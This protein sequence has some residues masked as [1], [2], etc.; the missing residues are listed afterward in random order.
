MIAAVATPPAP[1]FWDL[2][3]GQQFR[4]G[5]GVTTILPDIDFETACAAGYHWDEKQQKWTDVPGAAKNKRG[6]EVV[7]RRNYVKHPTFRILSLAYNLK[8]GRGKRR[9]LPGWP[10]PQDL[11]DH[12]ANGGIVEAWNAGFEFDVWNEYCVPVLGWPPLPLHQLRCAMAKARAHAGPGKLE[13]FGEA[14]RLTY[15]KDP[16]GDRL[17]RKFSN[18]RNPTKSNPK[19][20]TMPEDDPADFAKLLDYNDRDI[21]TEAEASLKTPDLPPDELEIWLTDQRVNLRGIQVDLVAMENCISIV[22]QAYAK[23]NAELR[24]ITNGVVQAASEVKKLTE[25]LSRCGVYMESLDEEAVDEMLKKLHKQGHSHSAAYRVLEIRSLLGSASIKKLFA[26]RHQ[27]HLGRLYD[28]YS[29]FAARTGRW[30]GNGPQPQNLPSGM[31]HTLE[32]VERALSIISHRML[33]LVEIEYPGHSALEVVASVLRGLL[34]AAPGHEFI[35]SDYSAIEGVVSAAIAGEEWR[36]E[37]FRTHGMIYEA[38][39]ARIAG[40]PFDDFVKHRL[41]TGGVATWNNGKLM[42]ITGG[43]HHPLRKKMGKF[44][45]L[46]SGFGGWIGAWKGFGADEFLSDEEIKEALLAWRRDSPAIVECW[47]GQKREVAPRQYEP[48]LYGLEGAAIAAVQ[49]R[50][51]A[52]GYRGITY[53]MSEVDDVL[54]CRTLSGGYLTYHRPRLEPA[55]REWAKPWELS[56]SYEGDN[57]NPKMGRIG[58]VRMSLYGGKQFENVI[59]KEARAIQAHALVKLDRTGYRPVIHSHDEIAGEVRIGWGSVEEF[60]NIASDLP[61]FAR[62]WPVRMKGGWRGPR[63]GK[64]E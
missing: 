49:W 61:A 45:E 12:V 19:L 4:A 15:P 43:K 59:Q 47:G 50:G 42:G 60:E 44:A 33:E 5:F 62:G 63:Y 6:L 41:D 37:V 24:N 39:A 22:E 27:N 56:L 31:F 46:G 16:D 38:S 11:L 29:Y 32:E 21:L 64:F 28:L 8:D 52:F 23:Y 2:R 20:W 54:Y 9:W 35:C 40:I 14:F 58:W 34:I 25:W 53:Q 36:L 3:A 18:P 30:T 10:P 17:L 13:R 7:G 51:K 1:S 57:K 55:K 26:F 48:C